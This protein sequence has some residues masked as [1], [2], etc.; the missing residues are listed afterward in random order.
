[1]INTFEIVDE[2]INEATAQ[3]RG[4]KIDQEKYDILKHYCEVFDRMIDDFDAES[5][6]VEVDDIRMTVA[7]TVECTDF[8]IDE[9]NSVYYEL[10]SRSEAFNVSQSEDNNLDLTF[11]F[12][13]VW[14]KV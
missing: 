3:F 6:D 4:W 9:S 5:V 2:V 13:S 11:V 1:M 8:T 7:I 12:P 10:I 14:E